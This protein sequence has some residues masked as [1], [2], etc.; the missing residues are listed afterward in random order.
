MN[1]SLIELLRSYRPG[2][3]RRRQQSDV[4][5]LY[6]SNPDD[7]WQECLERD[8]YGANTADYSL[9]ARRPAPKQPR[10]NKQ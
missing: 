7:A 8:L 9:P 2:K 5:E 6:S 3:L 4:P 10:P 1:F